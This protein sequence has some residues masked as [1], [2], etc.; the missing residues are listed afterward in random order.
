[1]T[2]GLQPLSRH[3]LTP[4]DRFP[5][6]S[7]P[8]VMDWV[9]LASLRVDPA[10]QR[11]I[12][13]GGLRTIQQIVARFEWALFS[14]LIVAPV[15][16]TAFHAVIDGQHRATAALI[17]GFDRVP[18]SI[19]KV[20]P[21]DQ[22]RIFAG[23]NGTVTRLHPLQLYKAALMAGEPW[24]VGIKAACDAA[25]MTALTYPKS[26]ANI[27]PFETQSV[28]TLKSLVERFGAETV[29]RCLEVERH[30]SGADEP[31]YWNA[32]RIRSAVANRMDH[33]PKPV[34]AETVD[35]IGMMK[36]RGYTR[37]QAASVLKLPYATIE[38]HWGEA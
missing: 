6:P 26:R 12:T 37:T 19:C 28:G 18:C 7:H 16:G 14:P 35:Q 9:T 22:A 15:P 8:P 13:K 17:L 10:Y 5:A 1:M 20:S 25:G 34:D 11:P 2:N 30:K 36:A 38:K 33:L 21:S 4:P 3:D 24:A 27:K 31:G 29:G 23:V 32:D